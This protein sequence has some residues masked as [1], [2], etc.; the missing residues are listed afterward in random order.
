VSSVHDGSSDA[1]K[2]SL[3]V[4]EGHILLLVLSAEVDV[5]IDGI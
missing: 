5:C 2:T 3:A 1:W 4:G